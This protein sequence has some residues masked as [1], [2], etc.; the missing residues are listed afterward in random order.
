MVLWK[1]TL[2]EVRLHPGRALLTLLSIIIG[3]A[4]V[5]AVALATTATREAYQHMY[6]SVAGRAALEVAAEGGGAFPDSVASLLKNL[7]GLKAVEPSFQ[8]LT[9]LYHKG[10]RYRMLAMG[11]DPATDSEV[12]D[13]DLKE[14][15]FFGDP[16]G[17]LLE[18]NFAQG[19][20]VQLG[21]QVKL[22][23]KRGVKAVKVVGLLSP[24]GAAG[25]RQGETVLLPLAT[26]QSLFG[27]P[28]SITLLSLVLAGSADEE[29]VRAEVARRLPAGLAVRSPAARSQ[30]SKETLLNAE[31]GLNFACALTVVLA[32]FIILNTFLMNVGERR[33]QLA[34][35]RAIGATRSQI[36]RMMLREGLVMGVVGTVLGFPVGMAGAY[37][38]QTGMA[39]ISGTPTPRIHLT[40]IPLLLA[41][42]LGPAMTLAGTFFPAR[43]AARISPTEGFR[44]VVSGRRGGFPRRV[45]I[46]GLIAFLISGV[47]LAGCI[48][49]KLPIEASIPSGVVFM[50]S[51]VLLIPCVLNPIIY[52][53]G[54][55]LSPFLGVEAKLARVQLMRQSARTALTI[56]VLYIAVGMAIGLGTTIVNNVEDV[57][58]WYQRTMVGDFFLR[59]A[60]ADPSAG[61]G[62][63]VPLSLEHEIRQVPGVTNVDTVRFI[64]AHAKGHAVVMIA[65]GFTD[66][67]V[68]PLDLVQGNPDEVRRGLAHGGVVVGTVLAQRLDLKV[69]DQLPIQTRSGTQSLPIVGT[70]VEYTVGG[71]IVYVERA[72]AKRLF[73]VDGADVFLVR[74]DHNSLTQ[75]EARLRSIADGQGLMLHSFTD[76]SRLLDTIVDG[77]VAGLWGLLVL[78][79]LVA[80]FGIANTLTMNVLE[81][82]RE[83]ALLRVV[84][85][86]R[87]QVRKLILS[88]AV[89]IGAIGLATGSLR[90]GEHGLRHQPLHHAAVGISR[91]LLAAR[92][93][94]GR[95]FRRRAGGRA[96]GRFGARR[97]RGA[98]Q[99]V[100]GAS[101]RVA[102]PDIPGKDQAS[103]HPANPLLPHRAPAESSARSHPRRTAGVR[104]HRRFGDP[105]APPA[106][107][108]RTARENRALGPENPSGR[109]GS[110]ARRAAC[111]RPGSRP[112]RFPPAPAAR[113]RYPTDRRT[114]ATA[115]PMRSTVLSDTAH[116]EPA[117][118]PASAATVGGS[119]RGKNRFSRRSANRSR[120]PAGHPATDRSGR[121]RVRSA[122][123]GRAAMGQNPIAI[124]GRFGELQ[125]AVCGVA[126]FLLARRGAG[127]RPIGEQHVRADHKGH[128]C[129]RAGARRGA[130]LPTPEPGH[131]AVAQ[132]TANVQPG[133]PHLAECPL[134]RKHAVARP[135]ARSRAH[136]AN[137]T[138]IHFRYTVM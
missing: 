51:F 40:L 63:E 69:G 3:V 135:A 84:A 34:I 57:R 89:I 48:L 43:T 94:V 86:T 108:P 102:F 110:T 119:A 117:P 103:S 36:M 71:F 91:G 136:V 61:M 33:R 8:T 13:Y 77:V 12:R 81:Q 39:A 22:L 114:P 105:I 68:L 67:N 83:I 75:V 1:L 41:A 45:T 130:V 38:L 74:A 132:W 47:L 6:E 134:Q 138:N 15:T 93:A 72:V 28:K 53:L 87:W 50:A 23:T 27:S 116:S 25:F 62:A 104:R 49:G 129:G 125:P 37:Y 70:A 97:A 118:T 128:V 109:F 113:D 85:M 73:D 111:L 16:K 52:G 100:D 64:G 76:L 18:A 54:T 7:P 96:A 9:V 56:G 120:A 42:L 124:P 131:L 5:V 31:Q 4:A 35:L 60:V 19:I 101:V 82:T 24:R 123:H 10:A 80:A 98:P 78:G 44:P 133:G 11:V 90:R 88:Q 20:H 106:Q 137:Q 115:G 2:R 29:A 121:A 66:P 65:R 17:V 26:A 58:Q 46:G 30:L 55:L 95:L 32:V 59:A 122:P 21:D 99:S 127:R 112:A 107:S 126:Q 92:A 79:F 14:G